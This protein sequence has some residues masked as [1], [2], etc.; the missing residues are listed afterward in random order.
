[1]EKGPSRYSGTGIFVDVSDKAKPRNYENDERHMFVVIA[2]YKVDP[3]VHHQSLDHENLL[4]IMP[5]GCF[6]CEVVWTPGME[7]APCPGEP[8]S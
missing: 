4:Q 1:M 2:M 6:R 7:L 3:T 5:I 8:E